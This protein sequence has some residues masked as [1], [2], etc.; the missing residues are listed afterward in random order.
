[1]KKFLVTIFALAI[2]VGIPLVARAQTASPQDSAANE[3][4]SYVLF[5]L[6]TCPHCQEEIRFINSTLMPKYG[7]YIDLQ[8]YEVST[9]ENQQKFEEYG[10]YYKV[11]V[12]TVPVA[13]ID[14]EMIN[15]YTNDK[16]TGKQIM[17]IVETKLVE[18]GILAPPETADSIGNST[19]NQATN[20]TI[21]NGEPTCITIPLVGT[22]DPT[23]F[24]LPLLTV[25]LGL[26]D[27]FNPCAMWV[28]LFLISL[29]LGME[30]K[31]RMWLLG[32]IFIIASGVVYFVFMAAWLQ[33]LLFIGM[34]TAIRIVIG[35]VGITI[36]G[37][38]LWDFW[39]NRKAEGVVCEVSGKEGTKRTF[40][41][42]K[43]IVHR[44][45]LWWSLIGIVILGFSVNLVELACSAG[46]PAMFTQVLALNDLPMWKRY[47]YMF[48]YIVF[49]MLD[50][51]VVFVIAMVTL[52]SKM[53]GGKYAK[54]GNL[55]GGLL[56]FILGF[57]LIFKPEWLMFS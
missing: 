44:K 6:K 26:L 37:K 54:Y 33:L 19:D 46:F 10:Y 39:K 17:N 30:D 15:G 28:L 52:K 49:Y 51:M 9:P 50:D 24:S 36:G 34:I 35:V 5:H 40:D 25:V 56:I 45:S 32:S 29:L 12:G 47:I 2:L 18:R 48:F 21:V 1:M 23:S 8:M 20:C 4:I 38:N 43:D 55:I 11:P 16:S 22:I 57:L 42:I 3:K 13:F 7:Q 31:S 53:I 27:G 41:K 14:G